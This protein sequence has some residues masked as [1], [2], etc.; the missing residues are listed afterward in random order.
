[1]GHLSNVS[2][3]DITTLYTTNVTSYG[4][5]YAFSGRPEYAVIVP[6]VWIVLIIIGAIGN[7][8]VIYTLSK[9]GEITATNCYIVN[10]AIADLTFL[11]IVVPF[12]TASYAIPNW[13]FGDFMC[14]TATY[15]VYV[16]TA[17]LIDILIFFYDIAHIL[18]I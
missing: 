10:L 6:T 17:F 5:H 18:S 14:K 11:L 12:T 1:M 2:I 3:M 9:N 4:E 15:M 16:S 8:L 7:G 13:I